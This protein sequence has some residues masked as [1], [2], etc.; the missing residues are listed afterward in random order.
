M[1]SFAFV[2]PAAAYAAVLALSSAVCGP[3]SA[4][5]VTLKDGTVIHGVV[6]SLRDGVY[7]VTSG[8]LGTIRVPKTEVRTIDEGDGATRAAGAASGG[9][10]PGAGS[11]G[12]GG[13]G[14][15][16]AGLEGVQLGLLQDP[17]LLEMLLALEDDPDVQ[18]VLADP[19][20]MREIAAGDYAALMSDPKIVALMSDEKVR[21]L[22][23]AVR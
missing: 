17:R 22:I 20:V 4:A 8:S 2:V 21:A 12:D 7:T 1:R 18:A 23:D 13:A 5:T 11:P 6:E 14:K 19:K 16:A 10:L 3:A 9:A 15:G